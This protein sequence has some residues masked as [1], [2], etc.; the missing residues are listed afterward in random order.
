MSV[1]ERHAAFRRYVLPELDVLRRVALRLTNS[2]ADA[3]DLVQ[4]T[5]LRAYRALDRFDGRHPRAWLLTI[6]RNTNVNRARKRT[7]DLLD[8]QDRALSAIRAE[9]YDGESGP[10]DEVIANTPDP[11]VIEA[12]KALPAIY[13]DVVFLVDIDGLAYREAA[14]KLGVPIGTVMSRLHRAR[15]RVRAPLEEHGYVRT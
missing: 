4:E 3:D 5:V 8:D 2:A 7:P 12:L 15:G 1:E 10:Q 13:R 9:G 6:L 11:R 14:E